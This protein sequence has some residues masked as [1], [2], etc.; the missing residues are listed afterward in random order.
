MKKK[1]LAMR[2]IWVSLDLPY[3][4]FTY[5]SLVEDLLEVEVEVVALGVAEGV[6]REAQ[7]LLQDYYA[8]HWGNLLPEALQ[9]AC[10]LS[11]YILMPCYQA[12]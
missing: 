8:G 12:V 3:H 2:Q 11:D 5:L 4:Q 9:H 6:D 1:Q 7:E 10:E